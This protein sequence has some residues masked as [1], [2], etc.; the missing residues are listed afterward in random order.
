[1][2]ALGPLVQLIP[3]KGIT[4]APPLA[5]VHRARIAGA[6]RENLSPVQRL[7]G[8]DRVERI[9]RTRGHILAVKASADSI[10]RITEHFPVVIWDSDGVVA[11]GIRAVLVRHTS[12]RV[13]IA[14]LGLDEVVHVALETVPG[15]L[16]EGCLPEGQC[17]PSCTLPSW[18][19]C[20][21]T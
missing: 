8:L 10:V 7:D 3:R 5:G 4:E 16:V 6:R 14:T 17:L 19:L 1:M 9:G 13:Q 12:D 18:P 21:T 20:C 2:R 11:D 15:L